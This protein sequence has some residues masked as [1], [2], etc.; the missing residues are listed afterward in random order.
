MQSSQIK[1]RRPRVLIVDLNNFA[2]FPTLAVGILVASLRDEGFGV[3]VL[4]PL[5]HDV[6]AV[7]REKRE[8]FTDHLARKV[9]LSTHPALRA[10]RD[11]ARRIRLWWRNR[12]HPRV[13][14][15]TARALDANPDALLLSAYLQH[16]RTVV[17]L[18]SLAKRRGIPVIL[19]GPAFNH[20]AT[21]NAW[22]SVPGL[23]AI[24]GGEVDFALPRIVETAIAG[25]DLLAFNGVVLPDG[26][27]SQSAY[28]LRD[29]DHLPVP[30]FTDFPWDRYRIRVIPVMTGR[31]CQWNNCTF[32]SDIV[33]ASGRTF[34]TRSVDAIME[35]IR[36]LSGRHGS[37]N[38]TFLDL[39]MNSNP[40]TWRGVIEEIQRN[41]PGAQW[42]GTVH[43]DPR[44]D[45]GLTRG[46]LHA[47]AAAGMRRVSFGLE[48]GSQRLLDKMRKGC[49]VESN[50]EFI[51]N[52]FD[53]GISIRCTMFSGYPGETV[54]DL[55][56]TASFLEHHAR[57][58]DRVRFNDF[59][60]LEGTQI[61][62]AVQFDPS[63]HPQLKILAVD[64]REGITRYVNLDATSRGYRRAKA[65][66]LNTVFKINRKRL[67]G[68]T[69]VF[70]GLM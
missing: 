39:K 9:H 47:A 11:L 23:T 56:L 5:S 42:I 37:T 15:E 66:V 30:D 13:L 18:C 65:S 48:T 28:P 45:N 6:P 36:E 67:R 1:N 43:V 60:I 33:S 35:E 63:R 44:T 59:S 40:V 68:T 61:H 21:A 16:F 10:G 46:E 19:G 14:R 62:Q 7:E 57:Y 29:L 32:C 12:P 24:V 53:A 20:E 55:R 17:A 2:T 70:D 22:R 27:R 52:A 54:E 4:C 8:R 31:G 49:S 51:R 38:F 26:S 58:L 3:E 41:A 34:R 64:S 50:S 69:E 25:G